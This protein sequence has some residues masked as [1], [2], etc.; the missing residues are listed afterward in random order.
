MYIRKSIV[1]QKCIQHASL[2]YNATYF[3]KQV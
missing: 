2:I 3:H 1:T